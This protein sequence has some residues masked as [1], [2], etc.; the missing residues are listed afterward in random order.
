M[1]VVSK[2]HIRFN[3]NRK[4]HELNYVDFNLSTDAKKIDRK[5]FG[6]KWITPEYKNSPEEEINILNE[7]KL[8][9]KNDN[10]K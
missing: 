10:R 5:F 2:Y 6:L 9:L 4:F 7:T 1:F 8:Y 3:E